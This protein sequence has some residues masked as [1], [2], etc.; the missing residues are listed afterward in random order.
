MLH[1]WQ[2]FI[3]DASCV[4]TIGEDMILSSKLLSKVRVYMSHPRIM[5]Y[6]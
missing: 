2:G 3:V 5:L 4:V 6:S 1:F